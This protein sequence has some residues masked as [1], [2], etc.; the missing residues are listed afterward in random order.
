MIKKSKERFKYLSFFGFCYLGTLLIIGRFLN[1]VRTPSPEIIN[2]FRFFFAV[3]IIFTAWSCSKYLSKGRTHKTRRKKKKSGRKKN[4]FTP[5]SANEWKLHA[6]IN[7]YRVHRKLPKIPLSKSL[8][9]VARTHVR[10]LAA[11]PP[12]GRCNLHS[13]SAHGKWTRCCYTSDHAKAKCMWYKPKELTNYKGEG[14]ECA[15]KGSNDP[16]EALRSWKSSLLHNEVI[17]NRGIWASHTWKSI[18]VGIYKGYAV[19]WFGEKVD[20]GGYWKKGK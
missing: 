17:I 9:H 1:G 20:H 2:L 16:K 12:R 7:Q 3:G 11:H 8:T 15:Y 4:S 6:L 10:D 14:F 5:P 18:G 19:I 13:W